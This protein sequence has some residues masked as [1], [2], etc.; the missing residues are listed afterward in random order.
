MPQKLSIEEVSKLGVSFPCEQMENGEQRFRCV[1]AGGYGY[2]LTKMPA[3]AGGWQK[4]HFHRDIIETYVVQEGWIVFAELKDGKA[5]LRRLLP[6]EV[7]TTRPLIAHNLYLPGGAV[8][9]TV[10]HG[11]CQITND[12]HAS[13]ELDALVHHLGEAQLRRLS[14][15]RDA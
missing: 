4:S 5:R 2:A 3:H 15:E 14:H 7:M 1:D 8:V 12:W 6:G 9:H 11:R 13:P 10:K